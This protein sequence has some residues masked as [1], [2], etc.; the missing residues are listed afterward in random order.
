MGIGSIQGIQMADVAE[1][2]SVRLTAQ[3]ISFL[4]KIISC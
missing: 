4:A 1:G 2:F 3:K